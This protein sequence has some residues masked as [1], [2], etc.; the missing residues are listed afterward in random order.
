M[1]KNLKADKDLMVM[2]VESLVDVGLA[3]KA[4]V[5]K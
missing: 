1:L 5:G 4:K 2:S 3:E